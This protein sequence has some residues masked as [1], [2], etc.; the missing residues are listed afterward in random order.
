MTIYEFHPVIYP[1]L[2]WITIG[3]PID[4]IK[5]RFNIV[6]PADEEYLKS[7][8]HLSDF[9]TGIKV[10]EIKTR[11]QGILMIF[12]DKKFGIGQIAHESVHIA[13]YIFDEIGAYAQDF[14]DKNEPYAYLVE[15]IANCIEKVKLNKF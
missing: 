8:I 12:R 10:V 9:A 13:D 15:W 14:E 7:N 1:R 2:V 3:A 5:E 4:F 6:K 11:N